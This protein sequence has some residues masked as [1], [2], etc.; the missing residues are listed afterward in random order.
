MPAPVMA[1]TILGFSQLVGMISLELYGHFVGSLDPTEAFANY[2]TGQVA[3]VIGSL[4]T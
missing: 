4:Q 3:S 2:A 1:R